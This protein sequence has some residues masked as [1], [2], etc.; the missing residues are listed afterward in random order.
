MIIANPILQVEYLPAMH[1]KAACVNI[2]VSNTEGVDTE[3][4]TLI[5]FV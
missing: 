1:L 4:N 3:I 5:W 2:V